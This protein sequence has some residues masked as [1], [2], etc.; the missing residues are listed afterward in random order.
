MPNCHFLQIMARKN[1]PGVVLVF[2][3]SLQPGKSKPVIFL[4]LRKHPFDRFFSLWIDFFPLWCISDLI[5]L[6]SVFFPQVPIHDFYVVLTPC[7]LVSKRAVLTIFRVGFIMSVSFSGRCRI[8]QYFI[9]WTDI[10]VVF[11]I[12]DIIVFFKESSFCQWA[13]IWHIW[14]LFVFDDLSTD[15]WSYVTCI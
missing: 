14:S 3:Q 2:L 1:Q 9:V 4:T 10:A 15:C 13:F 6:F 8:I 12:I 11:F 7:T 5:G